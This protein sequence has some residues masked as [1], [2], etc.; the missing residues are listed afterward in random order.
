VTKVLAGNFY[1][2]LAQKKIC[3]PGEAQFTSKNE[4]PSIAQSYG[5]HLRLRPVKAKIGGGDWSRTS[6]RQ[7][8]N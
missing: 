1:F 2:Q 4:K 6:E 8:P 3:L 7:E 5:G